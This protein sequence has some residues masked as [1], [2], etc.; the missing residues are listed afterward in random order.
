MIRFG[1]QYKNQGRFT[2]CPCPGHE[3]WQAFINQEKEFKASYCGSPIL[4]LLSHAGIPFEV[5]SM[6]HYLEKGQSFFYLYDLSL[7]HI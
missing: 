7:I 3:K 1:F 5:N 4:T 2:N 6:D